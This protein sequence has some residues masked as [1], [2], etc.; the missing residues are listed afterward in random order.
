M[1]RHPSKGAHETSLWGTERLGCLF[2]ICIQSRVV[3]VPCPLPPKPQR[4][5]LHN[6][7][8]SIFWPSLLTQPHNAVPPYQIPARNN[9][10][11]LESERRCLTPSIPLR[12]KRFSSNKSEDICQSTAAADD[13]NGSP[14]PPPPPPDF[15]PALSITPREI[16]AIGYYCTNYDHVSP[17]PQSLATYYSLSKQAIARGEIDTEGG[18]E[19][20]TFVSFIFA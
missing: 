19:P 20:L 12:G 1:S 9:R 10:S 16:T 3:T 7:G 8:D 14:P 4:E 11:T 13:V 2:T 15:P 17:P 6:D 18:E 5:T